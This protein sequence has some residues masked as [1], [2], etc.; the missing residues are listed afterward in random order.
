MIPSSRSM[1]SRDQS[2]RSDTCNLSATQGNVFGNPRAVCYRWN[3]RAEEY[4][5]TCCE[6]RRTNRKRSSNAEFWPSTM[7]SFSPA[8]IPQNSVADQQR[9]QTPSKLSC[10][11][12]RFP[13]QVSSCSD[14]PSDAVLWI[15]EVE[16]VDS[17]DKLKSSRSIAGKDLPNFELLDV[18]IA[19]ALNKI[20]QNSHF[21]KKVS[22]EEQKAQKEDRFLRGRQ[23]AFMIYDYFRIPGA[24]DT[25]LDN[26]DLFSITPRNDNVQDFDT[27]RDVFLL[28][29][30]KTPPD[31][32]LESLYKSRIR[33]SDQLKT[34]FELYGM[35]FI[36]RYR[37]LIIRS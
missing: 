21:K 17:V 36:R 29:I 28:S 24:H 20:I 19:F 12:I 10:W 3:H 33:E 15:K 8:E 32:V 7:N 2:L 5:E 18:R 11:K 16:M 23:I 9:L 37:G 4:T 27:R 35:K 34:V 14:F 31:D 6:R 13:T 22:L 26:A 30:T 1:F 25:V